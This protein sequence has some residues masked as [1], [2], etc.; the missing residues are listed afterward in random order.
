MQ[1]IDPLPD[2]R[3]LQ[4]FPSPVWMAVVQDPRGGR[5]LLEAGDSVFRPKNPVAV[6]T[7]REVTPVSL[8]VQV[9]GGAPARVFPGRAFPGAPDFVFVEPLRVRAIEYRRRIVA[10][11]AE[12]LL[13][14][15]RYFVE[16]SEGRAILRYDVD[17][18]T[19]IRQAQRQLESV[20]VQQTA[21]NTWEVRASDLA[22]V[23]ESGATIMNQTVFAGGVG[24]GKGEGMSVELRT[25]LANVQMDRK[26]FVILS[27]NLASR[28]GLE[29]GDR[30]VAVNG[31]PIGG[32]GDL[33]SMYHRLKADRSA[34]SVQ[35]TIER[36]NAPV[37][38]TY[39]I[40]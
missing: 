26:G 31:A 20:P 32:L 16:A 7:I 28:A 3:G 24:V 25:P 12:I 23:I 36:R 9:G 30:I 14:G 27:P 33:V 19:V 21:P 18:P 17:R 13:D 11:E 38:L 6:G 4:E 2:S 5:L 15:D 39:R 22:T 1:R 37:T 10:T 35:V 34:Q 29:V 40:R 8:S